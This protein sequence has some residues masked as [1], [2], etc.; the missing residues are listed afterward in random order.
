MIVNAIQARQRAS[1]YT[2]VI[3]GS[4]SGGFLCHV[5]E[6]PEV[7]AR[8]DSAAEA[9][10]VAMDKVAEACEAAALLH[11]RLPEVWRPEPTPE[12]VLRATV[13]RMRSDFVMLDALLAAMPQQ[14]RLV[15]TVRAIAQQGAKAE[16]GDAGPPNPRGD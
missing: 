8:G 7:E 3:R 16:G 13:E 4:P 5:V 6:W 15:R 10:A 9:L 2:Y 11:E 12:E 14:T 1:A